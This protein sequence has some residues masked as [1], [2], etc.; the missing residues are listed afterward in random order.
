MIVKSKDNETA[1]ASMTLRVVDK[2]IPATQVEGGF[3]IHAKPLLAQIN[4]AVTFTGICEL[5]GKSTIGWNYADGASGAGAA[6][7]HTYNRAGQYLV[8]A[9]CAN[10]SGKKFD[11]S[12]TVVVMSSTPPEVPVVAVLIPGQNPNLPQTPGCDPTQGP[13]QNA[14]QVPNGAQTIP[15][16]SETVWYYD[17][18]CRCYIGY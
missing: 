13:C 4:Q 14:G 7:Q 6:T 18:F 1:T 17:P 5:K 15:D 16:S 3:T 10:D 2:S 12:L 8:T 9:T 11:A